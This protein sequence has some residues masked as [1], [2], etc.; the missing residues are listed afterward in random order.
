LKI[1]HKAEIA[2][3]VQKVAVHVYAVGFGEILGYHL[4]DGREID[5]F[6]GGLVL[7]V[8]EV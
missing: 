4:P 1:Y 3:L 6:F 5:C 2:P 8:A 7:D